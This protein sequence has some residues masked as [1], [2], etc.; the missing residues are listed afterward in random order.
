MPWEDRSTM[1]IREECIQKAINKQCTVSQLCKEYQV[2]RKTI[3]KWLARYQEEGVFGLDD[4]SR[5]PTRVVITDSITVDSII[6]C[7]KKF[8]AW[9][10]R[11]LRQYLIDQG[12]RKV[13]CEA[14]FNR[15]LKKHDLISF[16]SSEDRKHYIRFEHSNPNDLWQMD[17]KGH[18]QVEEGR[19]HPLTVL[20]DHSRF[21]IVLK[22]C[23]S[24]D[25]ITVRT[26]LTEA[27][28]KYG[29]PVAMT[30]DNGSP[31]K[32][33]YPWRFS[34]LTIWL[35]RLG[36][37]VTHSRP[38]HPQT[39]GKDERFHRSLKDEVLRF[40]QFKGLQDTQERLDE[41]RE[42]YNHVRPHEGIGLKRPSDRY[43]SSPRPFP[44]VLT[45]IIYEDNDQIRKVQKNGCI[46]FNGTSYFIGEHLH[47]EHLAVRASHNEGTYDVYY[48]KTRLNK[49]NLK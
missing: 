41:W 1:R 8:P 48:S 38:G 7:R 43:Q 19:C 45:E 9:G 36:I 27:F 22:A 29:L 23:Y 46:D 37:R 18:F 2:S 6:N 10:G 21:S 4:R 35:M 13:P 40:Y 30:M 34:K 15:I 25:E 12:T 3:Y 14:T 28:R 20:D 11:K 47:G 32:G 16:E 17:F 44:E 33:S 26:A 39:Q 42:I 5:R 31:W 49:I 24:E